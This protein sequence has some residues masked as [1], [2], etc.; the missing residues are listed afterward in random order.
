MIQ[1]PVKCTKCGRLIEN[2]DDVVWYGPP[3]A[4]I[5]PMCVGCDKKIKEGNDDKEN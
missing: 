4:N 5:I 1:D 3:V 2:V